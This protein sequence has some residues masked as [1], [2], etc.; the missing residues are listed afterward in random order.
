[1]N[2]GVRIVE[3]DT[4]RDGVFRPPI[5][6]LARGPHASAAA[7]W[8]SLIDGEAHARLSRA[9][10]GTPRLALREGGS[11]SIHPVP[12]A[13]LFA[14]IDR[15]TLRR[16]GRLPSVETYEALTRLLRAR[17]S[18]HDWTPDAPFKQPWDESPEPSVEDALSAIARSD[19]DELRDALS[20]LAP[21][22][23]DARSLSEF[24]RWPVDRTL[25]GL[26]QHRDALA[27]AGIH[28]RTVGSP[29]GPA[30]VVTAE[31]PPEGESPRRLGGRTP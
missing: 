19:L 6:E 9:E 28:V 18:S 10:D 3:A 17:V 24:L 8:V 26:I 21:W 2:E 13:E 15:I 30:Y 23:T 7:L 1:M 11:V 25:S 20:R 14:A 5:D 4:R 27:L 31:P 22:V 12:S 16:R 29:W